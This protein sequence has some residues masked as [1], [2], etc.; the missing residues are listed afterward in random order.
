[1]KEFKKDE[2]VTIIGI[3]DFMAQTT[4]GQAK[5]TGQT[6][7]EGKPIFKEN[8]KGARKLF[9]LRNLDKKDT[10]VFAGDVPF[11]VDSEA[12]ITGQGLT[13]RIIRGNAC[14]NLVGDREVI[15]DYINNHN[16]NESFTAY[17][18]VMLIVGDKEM[19]LY[20]EV[21]TQHAVVER[22]RK[23]TINQ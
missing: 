1:M 2:V 9:T 22:I 18:A 12:V 21:P 11:K 23:E 6:T 14:I 7:S 13:T 5:A 15:K 17:D 20:P 8:K 16:L 10:L 4:K 19:P 3:G